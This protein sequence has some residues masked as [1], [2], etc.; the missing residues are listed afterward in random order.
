M[1]NTGIKLNVGYKVQ[2][3]CLALIATTPIE[4]FKMIAEAKLGGNVIIPNDKVPPMLPIVST[5]AEEKGPDKTMWKGLLERLSASPVVAP[6]ATV[7]TEPKAQKPQVPAKPV[8][9][10]AT[11]KESEKA[12]E[13]DSRPKRSR[14][15]AIAAVST[16]KRD[17]KVQRPRSVEKGRTV[18][19]KAGNPSVRMPGG[20]RNQGR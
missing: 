8:T 5:K 13:V 3:A 18:Q 14:A 7:T 2:A 19:P 16:L 12:P 6:V 9:K 15:Q 20:R 17:S 4:G 1:Q 11:P 10:K